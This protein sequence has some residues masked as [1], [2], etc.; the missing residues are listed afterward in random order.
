MTTSA[1]DQPLNKFV[2]E[3]WSGAYCVQTVA[4]SRTREGAI[5]NARRNLN[6]KRYTQNW[7]VIRDRITNIVVH[8]AF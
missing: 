8:P 6:G 5:Q 1:T 3:F 4:R 2:I 7:G